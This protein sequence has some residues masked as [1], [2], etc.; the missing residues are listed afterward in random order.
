M[1]RT[2]TTVR[3]SSPRPA[4]AAVLALAAVATGCGGGKTTAAGGAAKAPS[5]V[6]IAYQPGIAYA[7]LIVIK[8]DGTLEKQFPDTTVTWKVLSSGAAVR[9]GIVS[10]DE[11][12][13]HKI[14]SEVFTTTPHKL[15]AFAA[16]T[17]WTD[18]GAVHGEPGR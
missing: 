16:F 13:D 10:G 15:M 2:R 1:K 5:H 7:P 6:T 3:P 18:V 9:D 14:L 12:R 17:A 8:H 4:L 11:P